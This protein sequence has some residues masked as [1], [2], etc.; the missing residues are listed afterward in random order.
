[1]LKKLIKS[2]YLIIIK[3]LL[4]NIQLNNYYYKI[5]YNKKE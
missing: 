5:L 1:M 4:Q 2:K 3:L